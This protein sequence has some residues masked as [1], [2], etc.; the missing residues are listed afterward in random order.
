M[1]KALIDLSRANKPVNPLTSTPANQSTSPEVA[2][3]KP[4]VPVA[5][6]IDNPSEPKQP[7]PRAAA[8][9]TPA[10]SGPE[11]ISTIGA[12]IPKRL[13]KDVKRFCLEEDIELQDFVQEALTN[14]L[15][16]LK[17]QRK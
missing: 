10:A 4:T 15:A 13:H 5:A 8:K 11:E 9:T 12:R 3:D 1:S 16:M 6:P 7:R 14:H 17:G 2:Q